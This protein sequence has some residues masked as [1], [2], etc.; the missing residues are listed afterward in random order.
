MHTHLLN[1]LLQPLLGRLNILIELLQLKQLVFIT[2][3][4]LQLIT[5]LLVLRQDLVHPLHTETRDLVEEACDQEHALLLVLLLKLL[6]FE[7]EEPA[8]FEVV[9]DV[10]DGVDGATDVVE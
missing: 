4:L 1:D 2:R 9:V 5:D 7:L 10:L 3:D 8:V 6:C